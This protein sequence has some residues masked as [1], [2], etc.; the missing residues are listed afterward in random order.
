MTDVEITDLTGSRSGM[1]PYL[2]K[3][4]VTT[5]GTS[6]HRAIHNLTG[7]LEEQL[8]N[9]YQLEIVDV[10]K[11]PLL[12]A[13]ENITALPLLIKRAPLPER[14]LVGDMSNRIRVLAGLDLVPAGSLKA[15]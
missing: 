6:S 8:K 10:Q 14:R 7:I 9:A 1:P 12:A 11:Q 5:W 2:L 13:R 3:L 4:F 15:G